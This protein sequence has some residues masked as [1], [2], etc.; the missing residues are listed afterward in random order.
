MRDITAQLLTEVCSEVCIEPKLQP[1]S[2]ELLNHASAIR[3]DNAR[4][5]IA[6]NGFWG[7]THERSMFDVRVFNPF[8]ASN[9]NNTLAATYRRHEREKKRAYGQ[10]VREIESA[11]FSPLVF[12]L[13][14]DLGR[15]AT[16]VSKDWLHFFLPSGTNP[17]LSHLIG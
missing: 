13:T 6:A 8:A 10:R 15:E 14:G 17:T 7:G 5:D 9:K 4:L 11:S 3:E 2:G 1:L 16:V 12:S